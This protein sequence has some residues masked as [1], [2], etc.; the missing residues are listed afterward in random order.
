MLEK[1]K[2]LSFK[3]TVN[4]VQSIEEKKMNIKAQQ[5]SETATSQTESSQNYL[6]FKHNFLKMKK[7]VGNVVSMLEVALLAFNSA[8]YTSRFKFS[9]AESQKE[10]ADFL[11]NIEDAKNK[12]ERVVALN[13]IDKAAKKAKSIGE[14]SRVAMIYGGI[15]KDKQTAENMLDK[16]VLE[17]KHTGSEL[18]FNKTIINVGDLES[19]SD[20]IDSFKDYKDRDQ[21]IKSYVKLID[22]TLD[23]YENEDFTD[24][25]FIYER[26][27]RK[28]FKKHK[29]E[30]KR[31]T[32]EEKGQEEYE[33]ETK[34]R[35]KKE[36]KLVDKIKKEAEDIVSKRE[37]EDEEEEKR[38]AENDGAKKQEKTQNSVK[39]EDQTRRE[40]KKLLEG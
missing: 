12:G 30:D 4:Q 36:N 17:L 34:A 26:I 18:F 16:L 31:T 38:K 23:H 24:L 2:N 21:L 3:E 9:K 8:R 32:Q 27:R 15:L 6:N 10:V 20:V 33:S 19:L 1:R 14:I 25:Y 22:L 13:I 37:E 29:I 11:E 28:F 39:D 40:A 7:N 35:I 5:K